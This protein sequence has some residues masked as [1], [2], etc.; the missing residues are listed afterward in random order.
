MGDRK[1]KITP[2]IEEAQKRVDE[3]WAALEAY[4]EE[5]DALPED[6]KEDERDFRKEVL[7]ELEEKHGKELEKLEREV[8]FQRT[9]E[10]SAFIL[11]G[12]VK[13]LDEPKTYR[14]GS[15]HSFFRDI[16]TRAGVETGAPNPGA[17]ERLAQHGKEIL[18]D[19]AEKR[20]VTSADPGTASFIP[21]LYLGERWID[22][23]VAGRPFAD[24]VAK[25]PLS[26]TGKQM[27]FPRVQTAPAVAVQASEAAA[28]NEVD[29]DSETYSVPKVL[30]AGQ[31]DLSIQAYEF[32]DPGMDT[33][34]M[35]ELTKSYNSVLDS[36]L[37]TG[38]A[39]NGQHR[40]LKNVSGINSITYSAVGA[41]GGADGLVGAFYDAVAQIA[42]NAPGYMADA[43]V[44]HP[45]RAAWLASHRDANGS[46]LQQGEFALA[47]GAQNKGFALSV[48]GLGVIL[49]PNI[50]TVQGAGT[51]E[52]EIYVV[53]TTELILAE[54]DLR[55]RVLSEVL[56]GTLQIRLQLYAFSAWAGGRRPK[57]IARISGA[58]LATP[59]FPST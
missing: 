55:A 48:A 27:D 32:A 44:M 6:T 52:D 4:G 26:S 34:I 10:A 35:R 51:N 37:L 5:I 22:K 38:T 42:T 7:K 58:G 9:K 57:T 31:N 40:G 50:T 43:V 2:R 14:E 29:F 12:G 13:V 36:Q 23:E 15:G 28:V 8:M 21:P 56:S 19:L 18:V 24:A 20:D 41:A 17:A 30:I 3:A 47:S 25:M 1:V 54:G 33:V 59:A 45:R 46:L 49:D 39:A 11:E 16:L 53:D